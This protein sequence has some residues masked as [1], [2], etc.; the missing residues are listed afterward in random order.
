MSD[1]IRA[2]C[3]KQLNYLKCLMASAHELLNY[4]FI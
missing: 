1:G 3:L 4:G 2:Q